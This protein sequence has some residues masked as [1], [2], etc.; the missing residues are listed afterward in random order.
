MLLQTGTTIGQVFSVLECV[1]E[2][3]GGS[4]YRCMQADLNRE[5]AIKLLHPSLVASKEARDRF[6]REAK[7]LS[8]LKHPNIAQFFQW[9]MDNDETPYI[10]MEFIAGKSLQDCLAENGKLAWQQACRYTIQMCAGLNE[11]H[12]RKIVHRDVKPGNF[13]LT[14]EGMIKLVDFGLAKSSSTQTLTDTGLLVGSIHY[15]SPEA[16]RG[17]RV[18]HR[19]DIY[20]I[21]CA[22]YTMIYGE[23]PFDSDAAVGL[24]HK[25]SNDIPIFAQ[26]TFDIPEKL[27][28]IMRKCLEKNPDL[29]YQSASEMARDLEGVIESPGPNYHARRKAGGSRGRAWIAGLS[30]VVLAGIVCI[31]ATSFSEAPNTTLE[32]STKK[33]AGV[34][35][36]PHWIKEKAKRASTIG[37]ITI[38]MGE[39][40]LSQGDKIL[41]LHEVIKPESPSSLAARGAAY[42]WLGETG[43]ARAAE[44][45]QRALAALNQALK[46]ETRTELC[47]TDEFITRIYLARH[48]Y[49]N[50]ERY[51][52]KTLADCEEFG[53]TTPIRINCYRNYMQLCQLSGRIKECRRWTEAFE[54]ALLQKNQVQVAQMMSV[55]KQ[56]KNADGTAV[57]N[58][59][60][61]IA[62][63]IKADCCRLAGD[64]KQG[65]E[66]AELASAYS[67]A[68]P[69]PDF[70]M[71]GILC[72]RISREAAEKIFKSGKSV[73]SEQGLVCT[74]NFADCLADRGAFSQSQANLAEVAPHLKEI[75]DRRYAALYLA[76]QARCNRARGMSAEEVLAPLLELAP[77]PRGDPAAIEVLAL[78]PRS[79]NLGDTHL[80]I[81]HALDQ[82]KGR[83][84]DSPRTKQMI[85]TLLDAGYPNEALLA[86]RKIGPAHWHK[87]NPAVELL[88]ARALSECGQDKEA[89]ELTARVRKE[90]PPNPK[91][92]P[93]DYCELLM[94]EAR[95]CNSGV[96]DAV[97]SLAEANNLYL[98][99]GLVWYPARLR[100][101]H[102]L[103]TLYLK[104][105]LPTEASL[106]DK[107]AS[108]ITSQAQQIQL[109]SEL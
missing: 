103:A 1:G 53:P 43:G 11:I 47:L 59:Q 91:V 89:S 102:E 56:F 35:S 42:Y 40:Y 73:R 87:P 25:H 41:A 3:G 5:V 17:Q 51:I 84:P 79:L 36:K 18:D 7:I 16:C 14:S 78:A 67:N 4:V 49:A 44:F 70:V 31:L 8:T 76:T 2:G 58:N 13:I 104:A 9:G 95:Y 96:A 94:L 90:M 82:L 83:L 46:I 30:L 34:L 72:K 39:K 54:D 26:T 68:M 88:E 27:V 81:H 66:H 38:L 64:L 50:A 99:N 61:A 106:V 12:S 32:Q 86:C 108:S 74:L 60:I 19:A 69:D 62:E 37:G 55:P 100:L 28:S 24:L 10:A 57:K 109:T 92:A 22:L 77:P 65:R 75:R 105:N 23:P 98:K 85:H 52:Q 6:N 15:M 80:M 107:E 29:R 45:Q 21:G 93:I 101:L 33:T 48:E 97:K 71:T 63:A 20:A